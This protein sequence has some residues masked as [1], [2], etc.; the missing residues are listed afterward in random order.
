MCKHTFVVMMLLLLCQTGNAQNSSAK[1]ADKDSDGKVTV[2]EFAEYAEAKLQGADE[3][4]VKAFA[5]KVDA[6]NDG[7][8][9]DAEFAKRMDVLQEVMND[10]ADADDEG[11][12]KDAEK[13]TGPHVVGDKA[14]D[15]ELEGIEKKI[16]LSDVVAKSGKPV[17]VVFSRANW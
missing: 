11:E 12:A 5:K 10:E 2:K 9:S 1:D 13:E 4:Q 8:I 3:D 7:E 14:S 6:D 17:V 15:F 16:K